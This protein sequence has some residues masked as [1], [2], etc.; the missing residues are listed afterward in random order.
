MEKDFQ[1]K[2]LKVKEEVEFHNKG[3]WCDYDTVGGDKALE[4]ISTTEDNIQ[5]REHNNAHDRFAVSGLVTLKSILAE[6]KG[7]D[8]DVTSDSDN[9]EDEREIL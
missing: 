9:D 3:N 7:E 8:I 6:I 4:P 1:I 2:K 5:K